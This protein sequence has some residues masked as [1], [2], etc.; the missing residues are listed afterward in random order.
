MIILGTSLW[1]Y[2]GILLRHLVENTNERS[3][4]SDAA[5][6]V[7]INNADSGNL[8]TIGSEITSRIGYR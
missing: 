3:A 2:F 7:E 1:T 8:R 4:E 5:M 6:I